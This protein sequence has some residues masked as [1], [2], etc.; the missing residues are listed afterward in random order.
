MAL[1]KDRRAADLEEGLAQ[2]FVF[3]MNKAH[4]EGLNLFARAPAVPTADKVPGY[5]ASEPLPPERQSG[6]V[7]ARHVNPTLAKD[8]FDRPR[9][10]Q[11]TVP[12]PWCHEGFHA[13]HT[14]QTAW[15]A[16]TEDL[17]SMETVARHLRV[18]VTRAELARS[19]R[20]SVPDAASKC[21]SRP[22][23]RPGRGAMMGRTA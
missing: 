18:K 6:P 10:N 21:G 11:S 5:I 19:I 9:W 13:K 4:A 17:R 22:S 20:A 8:F 23:S 15:G 16:G 7:D 2:H 12:K 3:G 1:Q 14:P